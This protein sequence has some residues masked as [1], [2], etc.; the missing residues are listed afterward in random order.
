[1]RHKYIKDISRNTKTT[2]MQQKLTQMNCP[3]SICF[4]EDFH[5]SH[6]QLLE[7]GRVSKIFEELF[8]QKSLESPKQKDQEYC[9]SK[10]SKG[11]SQQTM[12]GVSLQSSHQWM[13]YGIMQS[14]KFLTVKI[15]ESHRIEKECSLSDILE[16]DVDEKYFL[17]ENVVNRL[18]D[19]GLEKGWSKLHNASEQETT[20][21]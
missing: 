16:K 19:K 18:M 7:K 2:E 17:S 9:C 11:C 20:Q 14:G 15:S 21:I 10:M 12:D 13:N 4:A 1:M 5:V 3:T 6:F 8:L